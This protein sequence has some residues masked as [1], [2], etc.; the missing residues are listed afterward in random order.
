M[1]TIVTLS[2]VQDVVLTVRAE[3]GATV[4]GPDNVAIGAQNP[5]APPTDSGRLPKF[6]ICDSHHHTTGCSLAAGRQ[7]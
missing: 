4:L 7:R 1:S 5:G 2:G 6:E 3:N